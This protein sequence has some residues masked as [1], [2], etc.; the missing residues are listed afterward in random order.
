MGLWNW[1]P[2]VE[3]ISKKKPCLADPSGYYEFSRQ[4]TREDAPDY[5]SRDGF[6]KTWTFASRRE[7]ALLSRRQGSCCHLTRWTLETALDAFAGGREESAE[8]AGGGGESAEEQ[9]EK[10]G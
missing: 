7:R 2:D 6:S 3:N 1:K 10:A 8:G 4:W 9:A 5:T